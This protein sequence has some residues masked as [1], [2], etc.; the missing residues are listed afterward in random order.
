MR[1]VCQLSL[2]LRGFSR[3]RWVALCHVAHCG[4]TLI[5]VLPVCDYNEAEIWYSGPALV[6]VCGL[7][8]RTHRDVQTSNSPVWPSFPYGTLICHFDENPSL[9]SIKSHRSV[10]LN[11]SWFPMWLHLSERVSEHRVCICEDRR[12][13]KQLEIILKQEWWLTGRR[14]GLGEGGRTWCQCLNCSF[15]VQSIPCPADCTQSTTLPLLSPP[16]STVPRLPQEP[17]QVLL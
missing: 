17:A 7:W 10:L 13:L 12:D 2:M 15:N 9:Y 11:S 1:A 16:P 14:R 5:D 4:G 6:S 8:T 3:G